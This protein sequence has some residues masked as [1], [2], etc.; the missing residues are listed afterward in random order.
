MVLTLSELGNAPVAQD[1]NELALISAPLL[2]PRFVQRLGG[3]N[4]NII[5]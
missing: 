3:T 1:V 4:I 5:A 2:L